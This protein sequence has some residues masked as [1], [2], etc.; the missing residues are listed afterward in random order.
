M[1][2]VNDTTF[3]QADTNDVVRLYTVLSVSADKAVCAVEIIM[4]ERTKS[5]KLRARPIR[6]MELDHEDVPTVLLQRAF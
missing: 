5:G 4:K 6:V 1:N 3:F 2:R